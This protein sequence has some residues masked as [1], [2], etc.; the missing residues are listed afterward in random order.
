[1]FFIEC[2][3][4]QHDGFVLP[5]RNSSM[6]CWEEVSENSCTANGG[7]LAVVENSDINNAIVSQ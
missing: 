7:Y 1:M 3:E 4:D 2:G 5:E 6:V